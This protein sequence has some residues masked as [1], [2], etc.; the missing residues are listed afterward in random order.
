MSSTERC[1]E[2]LR[3]IDEVLA[4][5]A[6]RAPHPALIPAAV[7]AQRPARGPNLRLWWR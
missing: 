1:D 2:I 5:V 3:L 7:A 4:E 6:D